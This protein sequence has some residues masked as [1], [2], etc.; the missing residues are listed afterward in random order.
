MPTSE[1]DA[2]EACPAEC[3]SAGL[4]ACYADAGDDLEARQ[5]CYD[6]WDVV[7]CVV[8]QLTP[9]QLECATDVPRYTALC[10]ARCPAE[11]KPGEP[12]PTGLDEICREYQGRF[13]CIAP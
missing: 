6:A 8:L 5:A 1:S 12:C 2:F 10:F 11:V 13:V 7:A 9:D 3:S 4:E